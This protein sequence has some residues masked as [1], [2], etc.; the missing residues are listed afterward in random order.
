MGDEGS[1]SSSS[2]YSSWIPDDVINRMYRRFEHDNPDIQNS[3]EIIGDLALNH[4]IVL[5]SPG[6][7]RYVDTNCV[8]TYGAILTVPFYLYC[9]T[10][11]ELP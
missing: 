1:S 10:T 2:S 6:L 8:M 11:R 3:A 7:R 5:P 9:T 4:H